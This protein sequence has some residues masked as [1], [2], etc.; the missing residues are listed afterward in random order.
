[1]N[2]AAR[3]A[4]ACVQRPVATLLLAV[5][6]V[7]A[8]LLGLRLLPVAP[9]PQVDYPAI[10]VSA[11]LPGASPE[12]MAATVAT[13][14]ERAL[15]SIPG[16][17]TIESASTQGQ[18]QVELKFALGRDIDEAAREVQ[19]AINI[20][21]GQLPSGMP[22]MPQ[23]RKVNPSQAPILAL[24]LTSDV[25]SPGQLYDLGS[26]VLAQKLSQIPGVGEVQ[27]GGSAL[28]AVRVSLDPNAL[29]H[30]GLALD[31]VSQAIARANAVRPLGAIGDGPQQWQL[32]APLQLRRAEQ[33]RELALT[34]RDDRPLRLGDVAQVTDG[35]ED[36]YSSGFHNERP[37]VLLI[38]S[39]QPGAN[40]I[41][42][43]DLIQQQLPQ[44]R[45]LVPANVAMELVMD[46]SPVIRATL[47]EAELTLVLA[48]VLVVLVVL[49]FLGH[50]RAA[51]VP[52]IAIPVVL[53]G[54][55]ALI[56]LFG[57]SLNTLSLMALIVAAVLV[58]DDA[59]VVLENI[60][61]HR[62]LGADRWQAAIRGAGEVGATLVSMNLA[63]AVVFISILFLDDF[64]ERLFR[65][66]SLT[67]VAAMAV[68][69]LVAL[70]LVPMLC[71]RLL[72]DADA[73]RSRWQQASDALFVR[74]R[75][76]Y[77]H[78]LQASLRHLRWP[79]LA[80]VAVLALNAWL[81][82]KVPKGI[83]P[84]QDTAQLRGFARGDDGLSFQAMQPKINAYRKLLL[85]DPAIADIIGFIGGSNGV[86]NAFIMIKMKPLSE[87]KVSSQQVI[88]RLRAKLPA[89]PGGNLYLWVDQDIRLEG[90][91]GDSG[92]Y[93]L[94]LLAD[95]LAPLRE[96]G[97]KVSAA[98]RT[99][100][101]LV[102][103]EAQGEAG[104]RQVVLDIDREAA[105]RHGVD[106]R[107]V[108][109]VLNNSF[110]QR[111]VATLYDSLNQYR[112]VMEL[113]PRHTQDPTTLQQLQVIDGN[114]QRIPLSSIATWRYGMAPDRV[115]HA[116]QFASV[117]IEFALA[118]GVSLEQGVAAINDA[119]AKLMLP[120]T[121]QVHLAGEAGGLDQ[122]KQ[123]QLW[124]V[125]G[126]ML[127]VYLV[128]GILYESFLQP[129]VI[130]STLPSAGIGALL[131]LLLFDNEL[132]L[133]ALLGLFLLVGV[134]MKNTILLVDF[135]LAGERRGLAPLDAVL[136]AARLR[137]RPILMTTVAALLGTLPLMLAS[138]EGWELRQP[139]GIAI[140][141]GL[142]VSQWLTLYTTPAMYL[143]LARLRRPPRSGIADA[144]TSTSRPG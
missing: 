73:P 10:E 115:H 27:V 139:L 19:A 53:F 123:R 50:W 82:Q 18:A 102:D 41:A 93:A 114:G 78:S 37:A 122:L 119:T 112:V 24:A 67:L 54:A 130:L 3:I 70:S 29:N 69:V 43:V 124:L 96:W 56:A 55:L 5:A 117:W 6:L 46:R 47:R 100:P 132:N 25:L 4:Q 26:T 48:I 135:A 113:D 17:T 95:E 104:M 110:S 58:V 90:G 39:R 106:L 133:I 94:Q 52:S 99:L 127:A 77:L 138:G 65:E 22:G 111:Q 125:L 144:A 59:I 28:P 137:L 80:F 91:G 38:V 31:D 75:E 62:E 86:N 109:N 33:Y 42:T 35:V 76:V 15:G 9:L 51:L 40:I 108:A 68:S 121:V 64:V 131:A 23:Y 136:E 72:G 116:Q 66:F 85:E 101:E 60:A 128:L 103:V 129:L 120:R 141:G 142:L 107:T 49:A 30:A 13:P 97:P 61:R 89:L 44:L 84:K 45:A 32:E 63:L 16:I 2:L 105:A 143:A 7:L 98:L 11:S 83:V 87:R 92:Q 79:L 1:M 88:D 20:A 126:A 71:A 74:V 14:L 8:G 12:S 34:V 57:F 134:V 118:P 36:R 140:V 81:F 21:R